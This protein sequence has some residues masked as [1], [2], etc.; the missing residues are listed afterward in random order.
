LVALGFPLGS[1]EAAGKYVIEFHD[2]LSEKS[3]L[4]VFDA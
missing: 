4:C 2:V 3:W 1:V